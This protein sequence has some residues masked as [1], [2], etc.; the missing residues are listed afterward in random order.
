MWNHNTHTTSR[1]YE[2][3]ENDKFDRFRRGLPPKTKGDYAFISHMIETHTPTYLMK[4]A[5]LLS[6]YQIASSRHFYPIILDY[7][8]Y[9]S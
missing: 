1:G 9:N 7:E 8:L 2:Q 5:G 4:M 3:A 6:Q